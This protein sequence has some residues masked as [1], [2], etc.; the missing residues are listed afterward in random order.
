RCTAGRSGSEVV[1]EVPPVMAATGGRTIREL[2]VLALLGSGRSNGQIATHLF[3]S[4]K[5]AS[6]HV[7]NILRKLGVANRVEAG[8]GA[9]ARRRPP[10]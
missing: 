3:I 4:T 7:S 5:T 8:A 6:V 2:E 9:L 10:H 1:R